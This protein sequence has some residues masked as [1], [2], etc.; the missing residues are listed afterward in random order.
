MVLA[1][2]ATDYNVVVSDICGRNVTSADASLSISN[3][4]I[5]NT[6]PDN[7]TACVGS[8]VS[9]SVDATGSGLTYQWRKGIVE[10]SNTGNISGA[11]SA[12]LI[13]YSVNTADVE[14]DYNVIVSGTCALDVSSADAF[15]AIN[16]KPTAPTVTLIQ[17]S[18]SAAGGTITVTSNTTG[19]S[20]SIDGTSYTNTSGIF[21]SIN[22]GVYKVTAQNA[23]GCVSTETSVTINTQSTTPE[24]PTVT[25]IQPSCSLASGTITVSSNL[26][27]L[28]FSIDGTIY[29]NTTGIFTAVA[30][31]DYEV[32]AQ[33]T[34][35]CISTGT[36]VTVN[37]QPV[38]PEAPTVTLIQPT[39][40]LLTGAITVSSELTDLS[41]SIDGVTYTNTTGI[42]TLV[43]PGVYEVT[44]QNADGCVSSGT[45]AT[46]AECTTGILN[47]EKSTKSVSFFPNPFTNTIVMELDDISL[48]NNCE[49]RIYNILGEEKIIERITERITI[50]N[51][52]DF[53]S[54]IYLYSVIVNG[55]T[56]QSGRLISQ[57]D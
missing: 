23:N 36:S 34:D 30:A 42:F 43:D 50:F 57:Q 35:E 47:N 39:C 48:I 27:D 56:I 24:A 46:L 21:T 13:V 38:T 3:A 26:T 7:Q 4:I 15:L 16:Q 12:A 49:L 32:T 41:F 54:G 31:G 10:L 55:Q 8:Q 33:N 6:E 9:F 29:T 5:I 20:F 22:P 45:N 51:T 52:N 17:P 2:I 25:L 37:A 1:D 14:S 11:T 19:L 18:C 40:T 28:S 44:A 53:Q